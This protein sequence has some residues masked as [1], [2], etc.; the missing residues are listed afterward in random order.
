MLSNVHVKNFALIDETDIGLDDK[1]NILTGETGAGKS[2][3][4]GAINLALGART[5]KEVVHEGADY[6]LAELTFTSI[7][8]GAALAA[9]KL[10]IEL[11]DDE[12]VVS[13]KLMA[14]G[15]SIVRINGE[16]MNAAAARS[17]TSQ[18]IDI[19]GQNEHQSLLDEA[20][21][22]EIVDR[23]LGPEAET[24]KSII[25]DEYAEYASLKAEEASL[26]NDPSKRAREIDRLK[27]EIMEIEQAELREGEEEELKAER[28][29]LANAG[30]IREA[31]GTACDCLYRDDGCSDMMSVSIK[32]LSRVSDM[33]ENLGGFLDELSEIDSRVSDV[34]REM[35]NYLDELPNSGERLAEVDER[36]DLIS[37]LKSKF[38]RTI[39]AIYTF[40]EEN[41]LRLDKL[42]E[43]E[44]YV[45]TLERKIAASERKCS[46][47]SLELS[48]LRQEA[49]QILKR[50][51]ATALLELNFNQVRFDIE[52]GRRDELH[53]DGI[54]IA[55]FM[56]S[57]NPGEE[58]KPLKN[59]ASGGEMSRIMLAVKS[60]FAKRET[61]GT[62][63]FDEIDTGISGI[64][65]QKVADKL[66]GIAGSH[67]VI[68]ITHLPQIAAMADTHFK[69]SKHVEDKRTV[70]SINRLDEQG[71]L[72]ELGRILGG[73][74][75]SDSV[76]E[77]AAD[78]R[79]SAFKRKSAIR[80]ER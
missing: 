4:L 11:D 9:E 30:L 44:S 62:L 59:V 71:T 41:K 36:L 18:L 73:E 53:A 79:S 28:R 49:A 16:T 14:N 22:L 35:E 20:N 25:R 70:V 3:L 23:F 15:K 55:R 76:M 67:Q 64:T 33:D 38:G 72:E 78:I 56:I 29:V 58:L 1:L 45:E 52:F 69:V 37:H 63:I 50:Q 2:I 12:I 32:A 39:E 26:E 13:R 65:A 8:E 46:E 7:S 10:G 51:I 75:L 24:L 42:A 57:L 5:S 6:C 66:C 40:L 54:D 47:H 43:F 34:Y 21:H 80:E 19:Y 68:C 31:L 27:S 77:A 60:V 48:R 17:I 61:I 74:A